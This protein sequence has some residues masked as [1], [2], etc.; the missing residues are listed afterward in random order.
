MH[1]RNLILALLAALAIGSLPG[2]GQ[3]PPPAPGPVAVSPDAVAR[4]H[5][6]GK[7]RLDLAASAYFFS[8]VWGLPESARLQ[9]QTFDRLATAP[10]RLVYGDAVA[11]QIPATVLRPLLDDLVSEESY[12]EVRVP[13]NSPP[14]TDNY[15]LAFAIHLP[16]P[17]AGIW[18][19][20]FAIAAELLA[21]RLA[22]ASSGDRG[23]VIQRTNAPNFIRLRRVG[24]WTVIGV[25]PEQNPLL[26]EISARLARDS[27]PLP[28]SPTNFWLEAAVDLPRLIST[29][30]LQP[31]AF[32][33]ANLSSPRITLDI[34]GDGGN[35]ILR[36]QLD[37]SQPLA[38][39]LEPW[40]I[41]TPLL[42]E[43]LTSFTAVR[44]FA[45][46]LGAQK[47]WAGQ[48]LGPPPNQIYFWALAGS[49]LQDYFA[50]PLLD[51]S[52]RVGQLTQ[53]LL[54]QGNP[55]LAARG[56]L[57][58]EPL[59]AANGVTWGKSSRL[60]PFLKSVD[61]DAGPVV[62]GGLLPAG[63]MAT[64]LPPP[65]GMIQDVLRR[66][67]LVYYDWEVTGP[68]ADAWFNLGQTAREL[69]RRAKLPADSAGATW[70][71]MLLPRLGTSATV[72]TQTGDR[73]LTFIRKSTLGLTAVE[74]QLLADWL[75]SPQFPRGLHSSLPAVDN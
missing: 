60:Q 73:Q 75:E 39:A 2:C 21:G 15:Q 33:L 48:Q 49:P 35:V 40:A 16:P 68:R 26:A 12:L 23:W 57:G 13:T 22:V 37:F 34:T 53:R 36:G 20:N 8:R 10:W 24:E 14:L 6:L 27:A 67:N 59:P 54:G 11:S 32:S 69:L 50:V 66:T 43:P 70:L 25:G 62:F 18:E 58:F 56:Y 51:A 7:R 30:N 46:W 9:A 4:V 52:N 65:A 72:V 44:G 38:L 55:W 17:H 71:G 74:L 47:F 19:T 28:A 63:G 3:P 29:F 64:N 42:S 61:T 5:W 1:R 45:P 31:S 41:P